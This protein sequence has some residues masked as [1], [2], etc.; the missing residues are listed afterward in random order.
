MNSIKIAV[1]GLGYVG[2]PLARLFSTKYPVVGFDINQHRVAELMTGIDAT[3]EVDEQTLKSALL[4]YNPVI[5][6][7]I[8]NPIRVIRQN[9]CNS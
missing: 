3:L 6:N 9:S 1:I 4:D 8:G 2:L 7:N 5:D